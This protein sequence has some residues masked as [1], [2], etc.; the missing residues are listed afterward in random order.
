[1]AKARP[2]LFVASMSVEQRRGRIYVDH[3]QD[4]PARNT[5]APYSL[6]GR[7]RPSVATPVTWEELAAATRPEDLHFSPAAVL[8]RVAEH[9]DLAADLLLDGPPPAAARLSARDRRPTSLGNR[10]AGTLRLRDPETDRRPRGPTRCVRSGATTAAT[11][12]GWWPRPSATTVEHR[13]RRAARAAARRGG[14]RRRARVRL[15]R[16]HALRRPGPLLPARHRRRGERGGLGDRVDHRLRRVP[17]LARAR[18]GRRARPARRD[19]RQRAGPR[20]V[21]ARGLGPRARALGGQR[22]REPA[23]TVPRHGRAGHPAH[24]LDRGLRRARSSPRRRGR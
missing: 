20:R 7:E 15:V 2:D 5:I 11:A 21:L 24:L 16:R 13:R 8:D 9:G 22:R 3:N 12:P 6:R 10:R 1:M 19:V 23:R 14:R 18:P 4:L 17:A